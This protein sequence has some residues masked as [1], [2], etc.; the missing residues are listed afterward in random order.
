MSD[1]LLSLTLAFVSG[2]PDAA[3]RTLEL[4]EL[5]LVAGFLASLPEGDAAGLTRRLL[6]QY[7]A[8][9]HDHL[10]DKETADLL[11][12]QDL[13][14]IAAVLRCLEVKQR[15]KVL[16]HLPAKRRAP[17]NL[18]LSFSSDT[19]GAWQTPLVATVPN[20]YQAGE[21]LRHL[22][23]AGDEARSDYVFVVDRDRFVRG[24]LRNLDL[25]RA[26]PQREVG[27]IMTGN[28]AS[29]TARLSLLRAAEH[30]DWAQVDVM[31]VNNRSGQFIGAIHHVDLR[32]GL[33]ILNAD[34][35]SRASQ[36]SIDGLLE[37]YGESMLALFSSVGDAFD[38]EPHR[39]RRK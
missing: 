24:R 27:S 21:A 7:V 19:V 25:L 8:R 13:S 39:Q 30:E 26:D 15:T 22:K 37:I 16:A 6:P 9:L 38:A 33:E 12:S 20:D 23:A 32:R 1:D 34:L 11:H 18:L 36:K 35:A 5:P 31:P 3:A 17:I 29:V 4:H 2:H 14:Y 28:L 10:K